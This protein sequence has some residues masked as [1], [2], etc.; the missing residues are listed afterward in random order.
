MF[1]INNFFNLYFLFLLDYINLYGMLD[2]LNN[3]IIKIKELLSDKDSNSF[4]YSNN[5]N[6]YNI[7]RY[8][9]M[10]AGEDFIDNEECQPTQQNTLAMQMKYTQSTDQLYY[11]KSEIDTNH[12]IF[13]GVYHNNNTADCTNNKQNTH[14]MQNV[15]QQEIDERFY[16]IQS[17]DFK[18]ESLNSTVHF[19]PWQNPNVCQCGMIYNNN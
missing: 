2:G 6:D 5:S 8:S 7:N 12:S 3:E 17:S 14:T 16:Q 18:N 15:S 4:C 11:T 13:K 10:S 19:F 9:E 1:K